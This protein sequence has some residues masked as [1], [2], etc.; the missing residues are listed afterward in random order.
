LKY[1]IF[2]CKIATAIAETIKIQSGIDPLFEE[3]EKD[4]LEMSR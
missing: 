1:S 3:V 2:N 4:V